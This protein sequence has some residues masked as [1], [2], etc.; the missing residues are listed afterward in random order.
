MITIFALFLLTLLVLTAVAVVRTDNLFVAVML[1]AI[2]SLLMAAD[3][4]I[5][6]AADLVDGGGLFTPKDRPRFHVAIMNPPYRKLRSDSAERARMSAVGIETSNLYSAFV[7][8]AL[9]LLEQGGELVAI[10][11]TQTLLQ[12]GERVVSVSNAVFLDEV[13]K[14]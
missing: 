14:Q 5:L 12:Q 7:W 4:F 3:F 9:E 8:L 6:D 11:P 2:F 13:V 10:T 1:M